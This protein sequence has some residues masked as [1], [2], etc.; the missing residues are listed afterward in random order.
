MKVQDK[1]SLHVAL[2]CH[3]LFEQRDGMKERVFSRTPGGKRGRRSLSLSSALEIFLSANLLHVLIAL[4]GGV[5]LP[6]GGLGMDMH[7]YHP[8]GGKEKH[9]HSSIGAYQ[10]HLTGLNQ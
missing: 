9:S 3:F 4:L 10:Y 8:G 5:I 7:P 1:S 2:L 6:Q